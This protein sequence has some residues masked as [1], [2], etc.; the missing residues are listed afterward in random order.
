MTPEQKRGASEMKSI[1]KIYLKSGQVAEI[2]TDDVIVGNGLNV[3][4]QSTNVRYANASDVSLV[5]VEE[6]YE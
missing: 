5:T 3:L 2:I 4:K 6:K 1:I